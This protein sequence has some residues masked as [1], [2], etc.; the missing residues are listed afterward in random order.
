MSVKYS[1]YLIQSIE[2]PSHTEARLGEEKGDDVDLAAAV[3]TAG[4]EQ[5]YDSD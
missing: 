4:R 3:A 1:R 5:G 2:T